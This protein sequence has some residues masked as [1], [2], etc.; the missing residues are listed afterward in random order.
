MTTVVTGA[1]GFAG[2]ALV[3]ELVAHGHE[4]VAF[5]HR[6][7]EVDGLEARG[8][9]R[10]VAFDLCGTLALERE[11]ARWRPSRVVHLAALASPRACEL[12]PERARATND[13]A[14]ARLLAAV[15]AATRVLVVSSAA[16]Y[17]P[18]TRPLA[19]DAPCA[20]R[21][22]YATTKYAA[23]GH[24]LHAAR[25]GA[26]VAIARPF[27]HSG[28][29]QSPEYA[30]PGLAQRL[31][32]FRDEGGPL[33]VGD[34]AAVRDFMH[35]RD[36]VRAYRVL[37]ERALPG[38]ITNVCTGRATR[39]CDAFHELARRVLG[40]HGAS[41]ASAAA[42]VDPE[43]ARPAG[44][45]AGRTADGAPGAADQRGA[46]SSCATTTALPATSSLVGNPYRLAIL[47]FVP[48]LGF[49]ELLDGLVA[50]AAGRVAKPR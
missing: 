27:N 20:P 6:P 28:P 10:A 29:G 48:L 41:I 23:E 2:R 5:C 17:A 22:V 44:S 50:G 47:P 19:E 32:A 33:R 18:S 35:V 26:A 7:E 39:L 16:V 12:D 4:V 31:L 3:D 38:S 25:R 11:L 42:V 9:A 37:L 45:S 49:D 15:P 8:A 13:L 43:L 30:L 1:G 36:T 40:P 21:G 14:T 46:S 24:A 34:L